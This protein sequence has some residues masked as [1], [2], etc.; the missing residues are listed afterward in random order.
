[1]VGKAQEGV[2]PIVTERMRAELSG[3]LSWYVLTDFV[4]RLQMSPAEA[5]DFLVKSTATVIGRI[6][7]DAIRVSPEETALARRLMADV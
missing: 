2:S 6:A 1:M 4:A 7:G 5:D 3:F